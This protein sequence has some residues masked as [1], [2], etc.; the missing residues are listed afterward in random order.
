MLT[1][2][3]H[4]AGLA[5]GGAPTLIYGWLLVSIMALFTA[6][7]LGELASAYPTS[8]GAYHWVAVLSP[9]SLASPLSFITGML[10]LMAWIFGTTGAG[11]FLAQCVMALASLIHDELVIEVGVR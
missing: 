4:L 7:S 1:A 5:Y 2:R 8:A 3:Q 6:L 9:R 10:N 11:M